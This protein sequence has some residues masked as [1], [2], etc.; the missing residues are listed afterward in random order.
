VT[1]TLRDALLLDHLRT[2]L[3][4]LNEDGQGVHHIM[5]TGSNQL[6]T[7]P[8]NE[9]YRTHQS[10]VL[11]KASNIGSIGAIGAVGLATTMEIAGT[12]AA[13]VA[14]ITGV[15]RGTTFL[16]RSGSAAAASLNALQFASFAGGT[17]SAATIVF[18]VHNLKNTIRAIQ[19]GNPCE[20]VVTITRIRDQ[21]RDIPLTHALDA[22][23]ER[24]L[25]ALKCRQCAMT[26]QEVTNLL[27]ESSEIL[28]EAQELA[29]RESD[30]DDPNVQDSL[31]SSERSIK[32]IRQ[33][34]SKSK[35][36]NSALPQ[37]DQDASISATSA[38]SASS[39]LA[40]SLRDR[41]QM[42]KRK[43]KRCNSPPTIREC[44]N[45]NGED[46]EHVESLIC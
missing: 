34:L 36:D 26:E 11:A 25:Q 43:E 3:Y 6:G 23:C 8:I 44:N 12:G 37:N 9:Y 29:M 45:E 4:T 5:L 27:V 15:V 10:E 42:H 32:A 14:E 39:R 20:K 1:G 40:L 41:I 46:A 30:G 16:S 21:I 24:Y 33:R 31:A 38:S 19:S 17:L 7:S 13:G 18:E 35:S 2:D 22:E 28:Q